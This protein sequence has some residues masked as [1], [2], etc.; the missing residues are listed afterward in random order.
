M[1]FKTLSVIIINP[2]QLP[3]HMIGNFLLTS[4]FINFIEYGKIITGL[5]KGKRSDQLLKQMKLSFV[6]AKLLMTCIF[7][8][9][10]AVDQ[11]K[12]QMFN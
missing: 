5:K 8:Y 11:A 3:K 6:A 9:S 12:R 2:E 7:L 10:L 4:Q 1:W